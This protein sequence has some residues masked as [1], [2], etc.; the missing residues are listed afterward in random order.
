MTAMAAAKT[1]PHAY[2]PRP[3]IS[4]LSAA[5]KANKQSPIATRDAMMQDADL[6]EDI[7]RNHAA[8][9]G[10][11]LGHDEDE[12]SSEL[13]EPDDEMDDEEQGNGIDGDILDEEVATAQKSLEVDSEAETERLDQTPHRQHRQADALGKTPS[14]LSQAATAE[15]ELSE[16]PSPL[17]TGPGAASSTSTVATVGE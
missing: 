14:K 9:N 16:P 15:D 8:A 13:S 4:P 2:A 12:G 3:S 1:P 11:G 7:E 5:S 17:P 6:Q 10:E